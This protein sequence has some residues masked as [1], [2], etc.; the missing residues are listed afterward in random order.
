MDEIQNMI[1]V[2]IEQ[3]NESETGFWSCNEM[4]LTPMKVTRK[5]YKT[6]DVI[7]QGTPAEVYSFLQGIYYAFVLSEVM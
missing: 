5:V 3:L 4:W 1:Q 2:L 6:N 7:F